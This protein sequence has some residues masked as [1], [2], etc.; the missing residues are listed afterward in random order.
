MIEHFIGHST[1]SH[2][3]TDIVLHFD[4]E[5]DGLWHGQSQSNYPDN[6]DY[7]YTSGQLGH[8]VRQ[9]WMTYGQIP[10][11][12]KCG[13]CQNLKQTETLHE[14]SQQFCLYRVHTHLI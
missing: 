12:S 2:N 5:L 8:G 3:L 6:N 10:F 11:H 4:T 9:K 7:P 1:R 13:D 14:V